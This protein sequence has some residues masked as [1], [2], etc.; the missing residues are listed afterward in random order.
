MSSKAASAAA[1]AAAAK[2]PARFARQSAQPSLKPS[3]RPSQA[4]PPKKLGKPASWPTWKRVLYT[5]VFAAVTFMGTIYGAGLKTQK[6]WK[7]EKQKIQE[8]TPEE[9]ISVL[10]QRRK[11]LER[12]KH[13]LDVKLM[14]LQKRMMAEGAKTDDGERS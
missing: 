6:E 2:F 3:I 8:A 10:Q 13:E 4:P 5:G 14:E 11:N 9:K 12:Q 7:E 1:K